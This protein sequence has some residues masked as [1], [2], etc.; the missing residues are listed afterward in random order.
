MK[1]VSQYR[2]LKNTT[3]ST[4]K[5]KFEMKH[6][7]HK[8]NITSRDNDNIF[9]SALVLNKLLQTIKKRKIIYK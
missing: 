9:S 1:I 4:Y 8:K 3:H 5:F 7:K 6:K 2:A